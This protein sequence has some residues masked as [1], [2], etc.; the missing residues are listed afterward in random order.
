MLLVPL[1]PTPSQIVNANLAD[2][3]CT[4]KIY[5]KFYG[6]FVDVSVD[7]VLVVAGVVAR[8]RNRIVRE[9]YRGFIGDFCFID[10]RGESDPDYKGLGPTNA[11]RF[12]LAYLSVEDL[13]RMGIA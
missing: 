13:D 1:Q 5:Q 4:L 10:N 11:A 7:S 8:D 2:Q 3:F 9:L 6:L 12:V